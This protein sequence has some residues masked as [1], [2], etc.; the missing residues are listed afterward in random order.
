MTI[1]PECAH[2]EA[3]DTRIQQQSLTLQ[4]RLTVY[5]EWPRC[6]LLGVG[7]LLAIKDVVRR[8]VGDAG[9]HIETGG[10]DVGD[11]L[12]VDPA[13]QLRLGFTLIHIG[14]GSRMNDPIRSQLT[15][16]LD[17]SVDVGEIDGVTGDITHRFCSSTAADTI[18]IGTPVRLQQRTPE[19]TVGAGNEESHCAACKI[20]S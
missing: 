4:L 11:D 2:H 12:M 17:N 20:N 14:H 9:T 18:D 1:Q 15:P 6:V 19:Q 16:Q 3:I 5:G 10:H 13:R 7:S 8:Q